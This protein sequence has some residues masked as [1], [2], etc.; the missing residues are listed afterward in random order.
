MIFRKRL[1]T[2]IAIIFIGLL[3]LLL[4]GIFSRI[5]QTMSGLENTLTFPRFNAHYIDGRNFSSEEIRKGPVLIVFFHPECEHCKYEIGELSKILPALEAVNTILISHAPVDLILEFLNNYG[6]GEP[7]LSAIL[8]DESFKIRELFNVK[9][10][11]TIL[12]YDRLLRLNKRF[13]GE[14]KMEAV[15][16]YLESND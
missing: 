4:Y 5:R 10:M 3:S 16:R 6:I 8:T 1:A 2:V 14:V 11:P 13:D 12:I 15:M 7:E 9:N